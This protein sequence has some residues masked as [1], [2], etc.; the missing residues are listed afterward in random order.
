MG[1]PTEKRF[2]GVR[3]VLGKLPGSGH[4]ERG[5]LLWWKSP[6]SHRSHHPVLASL[7]ARGWEG[8]PG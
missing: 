3:R 4:A 2:H 6:L 1:V 5:R 7:R 8:E